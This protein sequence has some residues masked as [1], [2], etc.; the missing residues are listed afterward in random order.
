MKLR[1]RVIDLAPGKSIIACEADVLFDAHM[2]RI[3]GKMESFQADDLV[4]GFF[5]KT[6]YPVLISCTRGEYLPE[7][8]D[9]Y[10]LPREKLDEW[11]NAVWEFN[12][13]ILGPHIKERK[14]VN[15][16]MRDGMILTVHESGDLPSFVLR[17]VESEIQ[18]E[19]RKNVTE[20]EKVFRLFMYPKLAGCTTGDHVPSVEEA[21]DLPRTDVL[22]W[23]S[24]AMVLNEKWF[25]SVVENAAAIADEIRKKNEI[26][27]AISSGESA[28]L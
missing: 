25:K 2:T 11:Y 9:A 15:L 24:L 28:R 14:K 20:D 19:S 7:A 16:E 12:P 26:M 21:L 27:P 10:Q 5:C 22:K 1:S 3:V 18:E 23:S 13:D 4:F 8:E 6:I 17:M